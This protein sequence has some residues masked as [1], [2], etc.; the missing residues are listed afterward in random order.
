MK[1]LTRFLDK[2][3]VV[4]SYAKRNV[5]MNIEQ[6]NYLLNKKV[7]IYQ[8][9]GFYRAS[10]DAVWLSAAVNNVKKG[11]S[12][13]DVGSGT[14][15]ASLCLAERF[16]NFDINITGLEIQKNLTD[17]ANKS[18]DA[19]NYDFLNFVNTD[20]FEAK[21]PH[22]SFNHVITNPPYAE[23]D[24]PSPNQSKAT[25]HNFQYKNLGNWI[26]F[27]IKMLKPQGYFY[28]INRAEALENIISNISG[29]LGGI[30]VFLLY[31]KD[32]QKAKR[33][34]VKAKKDSKT[35]LI[36]Q[37]GIIVHDND[38]KYSLKAEKVLRLGEGI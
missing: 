36:I 30:E 22:C 25:A 37:P 11:D 26:S 38:S 8:P 34:I 13:L 18:A 33:V 6:E 9:K 29:K 28:M 32:G 23:N 4:C 1:N 15:A 14:G 27:C 3:I 16:K 12:F 17:V 21:I 35:P 24:M 10:S 2:P 31:S 5:F 19:N 20:I 7:K